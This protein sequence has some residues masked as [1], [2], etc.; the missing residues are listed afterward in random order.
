MKCPLH[1]CLQLY[2]ADPV[3]HWPSSGGPVATFTGLVSVSTIADYK[4]IVLIPDEAA[5]PFKAN[6]VLSSYYALM[7]YTI[8]DIKWHDVSV[9]IAELL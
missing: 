4:N 7:W 6:T 1:V 3:T 8:Q 2:V 9:R 5:H